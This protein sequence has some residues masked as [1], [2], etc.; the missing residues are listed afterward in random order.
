M[1]NPKKILKP[2][3]GDFYLTPE[4]YRCFTEQYH[5]KRG[6]CCES[7][8]RHCPYGYDKKTNKYT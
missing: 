5:L 3:E 7:G 8:C 4:G 1:N 2:E 6:Y